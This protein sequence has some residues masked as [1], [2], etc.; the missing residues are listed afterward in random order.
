MQSK[1]KKIAFIAIIAFVLVACWAYIEYN[2]APADASTLAADER[3]SA[4]VL[5]SDYEQDEKAA[6]D[7]Y[8]GKTIIVRGRISSIEKNADTLV[9]ILLGEED[10]F[11][12]VSCQLASTAYR[13]LNK[14]NTND[15][16]SIKG[17]C[18]GYL[19]NVE[20]NRC[21]FEK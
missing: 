17:I 9:T 15:S 8:L 5:L 14:Y 13:E 16:V 10:S 4:N 11:N 3:V 6:N 1:K 12:H 19:L 18:I 20:L 2:R 7:K 21:V